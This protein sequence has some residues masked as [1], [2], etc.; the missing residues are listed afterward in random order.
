VRVT[1]AAGAVSVDLPKNANATVIAKV[2]WGDIRVGNTEA[3]GTH[4]SGMDI[5]QVF[6]PP[7]TA[8]GAPLT[9]VI[10]LT[11]GHVQINP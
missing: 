2:H 3:I 1:Q 9:I 4:T 8:T 11:A 6:N 10:D 5:T 7:A